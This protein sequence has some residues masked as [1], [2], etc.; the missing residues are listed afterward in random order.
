M[1]ITHSK[2]ILSLWK[3]EVSMVLWPIDCSLKDVRGVSQ[4]ISNLP[5]LL[6]PDWRHAARVKGMETATRLA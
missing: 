4:T 6:L 2:S 1:T 3:G 5:M